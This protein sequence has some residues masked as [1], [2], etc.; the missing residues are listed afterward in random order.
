MMAHAAEA[1]A[2]RVVLAFGEY[3]SFEVA[4]RDYAAAVG[5]SLGL[6][7]ELVPFSL[8]ATDML[9]V[10]TKAGEVGADAVIVLAADAACV[11]LMETSVDLELDSTLYLMGS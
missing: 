9:P 3:E 6:E 10:L 2:E 5:E 4:A 11:P 1:G 7:V 8:F